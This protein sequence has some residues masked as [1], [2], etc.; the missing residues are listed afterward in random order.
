MN[1]DVDIIDSEVI[2][3]FNDDDNYDDV[4]DDVDEKE[5]EQEELKA[6]DFTKKGL[7]AKDEMGGVNVR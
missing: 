7:K 4:D 1:L 5:E 3:P 2:N 6:F